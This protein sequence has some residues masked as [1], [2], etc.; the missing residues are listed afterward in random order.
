MASGHVVTSICF[1]PIEM[2]PTDFSD[3]QSLDHHDY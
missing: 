2:T 3:F 1:A